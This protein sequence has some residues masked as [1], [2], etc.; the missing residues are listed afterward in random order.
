M[1]DE[2]TTRLL[3]QPGVIL[4]HELVLIVLSL[5]QECDEL[6]ISDIE[7]S[8]RSEC[9][10]NMS[11]KNAGQRKAAF[12]EL[13]KPNEEYHKLKKDVMARDIEIRNAGAQLEYQRNLLKVYIA[14]VGR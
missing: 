5:K 11:L 6:K 14:I 3:A 13:L 7:E 2:L 4:T 10:M 8:V 12:I 1:S 9:D